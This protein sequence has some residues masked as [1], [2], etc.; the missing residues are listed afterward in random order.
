MNAQHARLS[1]LLNVLA[2]ALHNGRDPKPAFQEFVRAAARHFADEER[3]MAEVRY[4]GAAAHREPATFG[5]LVR[6]SG[7]ADAIQRIR[8]ADVAGAG[9]CDGHQDGAASLARHPHRWRAP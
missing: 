2:E 4:A 8:L 7:R 3:L 1:G 9:V 6:E 5:I